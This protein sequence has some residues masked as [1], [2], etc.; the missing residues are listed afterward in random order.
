[1]VIMVSAAIFTSMYFWPR[2]LNIKVE[3]VQSIS[4]ISKTTSD[5]LTISPDDYEALINELNDA[6]FR[7]T[8]TDVKAVKDMCYYEIKYKD[9]SSVHICDLNYRRYNSDGK[10]VEDYYI[11]EYSDILTDMVSESFYLLNQ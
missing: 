7:M 11:V 4:F 2:Q 3:E 10:L 1:M 8:L 5:I 6:K 9:G